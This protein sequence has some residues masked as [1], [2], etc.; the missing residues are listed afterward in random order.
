M[1]TTKPT[2]FITG[3]AGGFGQAVARTFVRQGWYVG[4]YDLSEAPLT[5]LVSSL[6]GP[7]VA[8]CGTLDVTDIESTRQAIQHFGE[9][10]GGQLRVLF[11]NAGITGVGAFTDVSIEHHRKVI[12][13]NLFGVMNVA[14]AAIPLMRNTP[15]AHLINVSSASA[16]HGNPELVS[17]SAT[18]RAV[19]S[20][21][22]SLDIGLEADGIRVS[23]LL[24]MYAKT[25]IILDYL[26]Q[27]RKLSDKDIKLTPDDI[28]AATWKVVQTGKFRTYVGTDTKVFAP[29][30]RL[31]PYRIRKWV[32]RKVIGW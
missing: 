14:H 17:Y 31:F 29:L 19:L 1:S 25:P 22:E 13:V 8:C 27:H 9:H 30:S 10:T 23:D 32:S 16:L 5:E 11:N 3:A 6:G 2:I 7:D 4:L 12:D 20:F 28:A 21:T 26:S 24:P 18:K 15:G